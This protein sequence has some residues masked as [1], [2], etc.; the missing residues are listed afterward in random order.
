MN[1]E[2]EKMYVSFLCVQIGMLWDY[3]EAEPFWLGAETLI[4]FIMRMKEKNVLGEMN[5]C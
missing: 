5:H 3:N 1:T 4:F 2:E